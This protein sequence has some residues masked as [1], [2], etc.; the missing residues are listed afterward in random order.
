MSI[1]ARLQ[2][3]ESCLAALR[4]E[5]TPLFLGKESELVDFPAV[6]PTFHPLVSIKPSTPEKPR[7][8]ERPERR[9]RVETEELDLRRE[10]VPKKTAPR[11]IVEARL[12]RV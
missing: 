12:R 2:E 4:L 6:F 1:L 7:I 8:S 3:L 11:K 10:I 5:K 9:L